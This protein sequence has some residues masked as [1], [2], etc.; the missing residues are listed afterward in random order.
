MKYDA[1]KTYRCNEFFVLH[2]VLF[3]R[4]GLE[5]IINYAANNNGIV[6]RYSR[7]LFTEN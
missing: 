7:K 1:M 6:R 4:T 5:I 3:L 2:L